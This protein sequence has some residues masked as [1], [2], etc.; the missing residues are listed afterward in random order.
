MKNIAVIMNTNEV[1]GAERSLVFQLKNHDE[2]SLT[3]FV[4]RITS[5]KKLEE[6][7]KVSGFK[8]IKYYNYPLSLYSLSRNNFKFNLSVFKDLYRLVFKMGEF[9]ELRD[10]D[11][12][13]LNGN[14]AA[15]LFFVKNRMLQFK[16]KVVWHLRDYYHSNKLTNTVWSILNNCNKENLSFIC[17]SNSVKK[18]LVSSPW[19]N[20]PTEVIYNPVGEIFPIRDTIKKIKTIGFVSMMAPWKGVHEIIL[21]SKLFESELEALGV[22]QVKVYGGNIYKTQGNHSDYSKQ[23][24]RLYEKFS[25][26][27]LTFEGHKEPSEIFQEI[28]CLIHYSLSPEPFGRVILEAFDAGIP[29]ISTCLGGAAELVQSQVTGIKVFPHDRQGLF[30]AIE[31]LIENK[32]KTFKLITSGIEKSKTIQKNISFSMK[33]VLEI[34][35][36]S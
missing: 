32:V 28:D 12:V 31:Q 36:A 35:V 1:G 22:T 6:F 27:L 9:S 4:P 20:F 7:L 21:W 14:K 16:G 2:S 17:N 5:S 24:K 34:G 11:M 10:F 23:I 29:V 30:L 13:Y 18:S 19:K 3:F 26:K 8:N 33:K 25:S 15:F